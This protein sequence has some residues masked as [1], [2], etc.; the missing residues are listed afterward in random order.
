MLNHAFVDDVGV[1]RSVDAKETEVR[2]A[3]PRFH[4][5]HNETKS[6]FGE[7]HVC[8]GLDGLLFGSP[9]GDDE[10]GAVA[11]THILEVVVMSGEID[12]EVADDV[13][14]ELLANVLVGKHQAARHTVRPARITV[15]TGRHQGMVTQRD[16]K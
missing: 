11:R 4:V 5:E 7:D 15:G 1:P 12:V 8:T 2:L 14:L 10:L 6:L 16:A 3:L 9:T 13:L